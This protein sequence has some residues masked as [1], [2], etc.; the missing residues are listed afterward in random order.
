M[1]LRVKDHDALLRASQ[2]LIARSAMA[3][4]KAKT[5]IAKSNAL[6]TALERNREA[7]LRETAKAAAA[8]NRK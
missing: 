7:S 8:G 6:K 1:S 5:I 2:E 3:R 4:R